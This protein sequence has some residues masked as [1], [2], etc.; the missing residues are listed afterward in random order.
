M[1]YERDWLMGGYCS[2]WFISVLYRVTLSRNNVDQG[3]MDVMQGK[4]VLA[5]IDVA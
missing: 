3:D 1:F 5:N 2:D 4:N